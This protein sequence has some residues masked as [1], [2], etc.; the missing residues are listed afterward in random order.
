[1]TPDHMRGILST[2]HLRFPLFEMKARA[3]GVHSAF[4]RLLCQHRSQQLA[5]HTGHHPHK[6]TAKFDLYARPGPDH[7]S[8][9]RACRTLCHDRHKRQ[10]RSIRQDRFTRRCRLATL[11]SLMPPAEYLLGV[12]LPPPGHVRYPRDLVPLAGLLATGSPVPAIRGSFAIDGRFTF[13]HWRSVPIVC[14]PFLCSGDASC[15]LT[16]L[17]SRSC[18][19]RGPCV[20]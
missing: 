16:P 19:P 2:A 17:C 10:P 11:S 1:M 18:A 14:C 8:R 7:F 4:V 15:P 5:V 13:F 6:H 20:G 3:K 9:G 12:E